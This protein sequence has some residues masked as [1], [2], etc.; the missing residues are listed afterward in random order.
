MFTFCFKFQIW[1]HRINIKFTEL[2]VV[3]VVV[4]WIC[5]Y[6]WRA[7]SNAASMAFFVGSQ[8]PAHASATAMMSGQADE[9]K[10]VGDGDGNGRQ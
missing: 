4:S 10:K 2:D 9:L 3:I 1:I 5:E 7:S 8:N 6:L